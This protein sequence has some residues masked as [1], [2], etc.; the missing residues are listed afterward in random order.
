MKK[1]L[2]VATMLFTAWCNAFPPAFPPLGC[3]NGK[4]VCVCD[5]DSCRWIWV[6][7]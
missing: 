6:C 5:G 7:R 3:E 2:L 4:T 1:K